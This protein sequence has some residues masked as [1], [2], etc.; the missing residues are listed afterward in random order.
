[1]TDIRSLDDLS[2][3]EIITLGSFCE[4]IQSSPAWQM[5]RAMYEQQQFRHMMSTEAHEQ[6]RREGIYAS[7]SGFMD[8]IAHMNLFIT[9]KDKLLEQPAPSEDVPAV[10]PYLEDE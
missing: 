6:K 8:F 1:M 2:P 9:T 4:T 10:P 7:C 5:L 3:D